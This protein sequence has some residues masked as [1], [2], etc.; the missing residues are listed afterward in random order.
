[1][2]RNRKLSQHSK[3][4]LAEMLRGGAEWFYGYD[5]IQQTGIRSGT[6]YP[7]LIRFEQRGYLEAIWLDP[8]EPGRP[9]RHAYRLTQAGRELAK[10]NMP[11]DNAKSLDGEKAVTR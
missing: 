3:L 9:P 5:L 2:L 10:A 1:M 4:V 8:A 7:M 11:A 6:L